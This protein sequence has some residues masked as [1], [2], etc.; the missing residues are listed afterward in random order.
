MYVVFSN[1]NKRIRE[2]AGM[3]RL[4]KYKYS[5]VNKSSYFPQAREIN[6][7][8]Y[9]QRPHLLTFEIKPSIPPTKYNDLFLYKY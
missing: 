8:C 4:V 2:H 9:K 6:V 5:W 1:E 7:Y 3:Q